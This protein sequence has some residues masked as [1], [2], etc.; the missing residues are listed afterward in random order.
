MN[1]AVLGNSMK[2]V[3]KYINIELVTTERWL[4]KLVVYPKYEAALR[5]NESLLA[6]KTTPRDPARNGTNRYK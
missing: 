6:V 4:L 1:N 5:F 3:W 2:N